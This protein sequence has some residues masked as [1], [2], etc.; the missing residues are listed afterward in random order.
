MSHTTVFS[1]RGHISPVS[2]PNELYDHVLG[3]KKKK[4]LSYDLGSISGSVCSDPLEMDI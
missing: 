2:A 3:F 4:I 1:P